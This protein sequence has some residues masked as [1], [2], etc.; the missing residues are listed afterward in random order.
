MAAQTQDPSDLPGDPSDHP[1]ADLTAPGTE[2]FDVVVIGGGP[3]GENAA[4]YAIEGG[5]S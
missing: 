1:P 2:T 4:Q 3:V 5:L